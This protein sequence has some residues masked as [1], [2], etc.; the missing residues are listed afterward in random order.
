MWGYTTRQVEK[1]LSMDAPTLRSIVRTGVV[2]PARGPGR[3]LRFTFQDLVLLRAAAELRQANVSA[4]KIRRA[5]GKLRARLGAEASLSGLQI[6]AY[7][8]E[9]VV[10]DSHGAWHPDSGQAVF[11]FEVREIAAQVAPLVDDALRERRDAEHLSAED[12]Y[13]W[14][15][16]VEPAAPEQAME[17]Y[18]RALALEPKHTQ[19]HV[20]LGRLLHERGDLDGALLHYQRARQS[21]AKDPTAAFNLGVVQ[22]DRGEL[23]AALRTYEQALDL[24]ATNAD[25][26]FNLAGLYE[27][28]G[29]KA[30]A[31]RHMM[32]YRR[33][34]GSGTG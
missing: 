34:R 8:D 28:L 13:R 32:D 16:E 20:N 25:A 9:V 17:S 26:H 30:E 15:C 4:A 10:R 11:D 29:R 12:W 22:Q 19:A 5:I 3:E 18:R 2:E 6:A 14:G 23:E 31:L 24:D 21:D 1:M 33:L 7:G 27:Q